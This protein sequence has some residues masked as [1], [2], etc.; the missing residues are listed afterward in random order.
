MTI[1]EARLEEVV[2]RNFRM[3]RDT[4]LPLSPLTLIIGPNS[5]GKSTALEGLHM[6]VSQPTPARDMLTLGVEPGPGVQI[7]IRANWAAPFANAQTA[8]VSPSTAASGSYTFLARSNREPAVPNDVQA[9]LF[10]LLRRFQIYR[11]NANA[12]AA[13]TPL[14]PSVQLQWDGSGLSGALD[15]LRDEQPERFEDFN[16]ELRAWLPEFDRVLFRTPSSGHRSITLRRAGDAA[17]VPVR[18]LSMGTQLALG[19]M[20]LGY[21]PDVPPIFAIEEPETG[22]HPRLLRKVHESLYRLAHPQEFGLSYPAK[23]VILTT[24]SPLLLDLFRDDPES[25]VIAS[26]Q[27][28]DA[29]FRRLSDI[30]GLAEVVADMRLSDAWYLGILG[31]VPTE[32]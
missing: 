2:F 20:A 28:P 6:F 25:V 27:G 32:G 31:G 17:A 21:V 26:R 1:A 13:D 19:I 3:L 22:V 23:Q 24:H 12:L 14:H 9:Q 4:T 16:E 30:S 11:L 10:E 15:R 7:E 18:A 8:L 29:Q 5:S